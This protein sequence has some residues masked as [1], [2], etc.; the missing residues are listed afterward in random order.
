[1]GIDTWAD[2]LEVAEQV[3]NNVVITFEDDDIVT[4]NNFTLANLR[5]DVLL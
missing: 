5:D 4:I 2:L 3:G 1:V